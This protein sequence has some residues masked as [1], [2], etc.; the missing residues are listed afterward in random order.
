[1]KPTS[2]DHDSSRRSFL[3]GMAATGALAF[4]TF[5]N[6]TGEFMIPEPA[7]SFEPNT[8]V[9]IDPDGTTTITVAKSEMGQGV[10]TS[11]AMI[12]AD[13][14]D[15]DWSKVKIRQAR[16]D[17]GNGGLGT[18][19]SGSVRWSY[20]ML[21]KAGA[22]VRVMLISAAAKKWGIAESSCI[23]NNGVISEKN[24]TRTITYGELTE[25]AAKITVPSNPGQKNISDFRIIGTR[26]H[27]IDTP[28][29]VSGKAIYGLDVRIPGMKFAVMVTPIAIGA[30]IKSFDATETLKV[31]GVLKAENV[32][33][34]GLVVLA[35]NTYAA[36]KGR[37]ALQIDWNMGGNS[38]LNSAKI[39]EQMKSKIGTVPDVPASSFKKNEAHYEL[40][41]LAHATMEV[42]NCVA[43]VKDSSAE[44][45]CPTQVG[46]DVRNTVASITGFAAK[47]VIVNTTLLGGGFGRRLNS[48]YASIATRISKTFKVPVLFMFSRQDDMRNDA[49]R[50]ASYHVCKG[51]LDA[52]GKVTGWVHRTVKGGQNNPP[53]SIPSPDSGSSSQSI[54]FPVN[55]GAWRSVGNTSSVFVN[56]C[57]IDELAVAA[58]KDPFEFRRDLL[59]QG[60]L[61][62]VLEKAAELAEWSKPLPKGW[63]R[64]IAC[65]HTD[66]SPMA[67]VVEVSV[68]DAGILKVERIVA[69][70]DCGI[71]INPMGVEAQ[72]Q[73]AAVDALSTALK[74]EITIENG[75]VKQS[76]FRDFE[77]LRMNEMP[78]I[79]VH[80]MPS[81][82]SPNGMGEAGFPSVSPALCNAIFNATGK[83]V[84]TLPIQKTSLAA[85]ETP[86]ISNHGE[87]SVFPSPFTTS[88]K[89]DGKFNTPV[90][91]EI[92]LSIQ[93]LLGSTLLETRVD[94]GSDG[95]FLQEINFTPASAGVYF[96][97]VRSGSA[98]IMRKIVKE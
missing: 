65:V 64:G 73:G 33:G 4:S 32:S 27:H 37:D 95:R 81:T 88:F 72:I 35:E 61:R 84:R 23:T 89:V 60:Q 6:A 87:M 2:E 54:N 42:M 82:G 62:S 55:T 77:W 83:R 97:T 66:Y 28:D 90:S 21:R 41:Y 8:W 46:D 30:S 39:N 52:N 29:I 13:E 51:G 34:V 96:L 14:M 9:K 16:P 76:T 68:S 58:G 85:V 63:G 20:D 25:D 26:K 49:Y 7:Q 67:H 48:D 11:L 3:L 22:T 50:P 71:A 92:S 43:D 40:P 44:V 19:G 31:K 74:S 59:P 70:V 98:V 80:I 36:L 91:G 56:E 12:V 78:K 94:L 69:V 1:M 75:G 86:E 18:G 38:T 93:N 53:Y 10:R 17:T 47:N 15:A 45:W 24:G 57:F 79:E 5:S